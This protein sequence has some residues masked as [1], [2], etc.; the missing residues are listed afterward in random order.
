MGSPGQI[1]KLIVDLRD[2]SKIQQQLS[3]A[4][5]D[6]LAAQLA[7]GMTY[8]RFQKWLK[9]AGIKISNSNVTTN[10]ARLLEVVKRV[11]GKRTAVKALKERFAKSN[12]TISKD[13]QEVTLA[14]VSD[15]LDVA[16]DPN[17]PQGRDVIFS[18]ADKSNAAVA[19]EI[20][21]RER[22]DRKKLKERELN[23]RDLSKIEAG[24]KQ[25]EKEVGENPKVKAGMDLIREGVKEKA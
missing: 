24:L 4:Q 13:L 22:E 3:D 18:A 2:D 1:L 15:V 8:T 16:G 19:I 20:R 23:Q 14:L 9:D 6:E 7:G 10:R 11:E 5:W 12:T 17:S 21:E 25:I